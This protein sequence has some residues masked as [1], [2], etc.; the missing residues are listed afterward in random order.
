MLEF[1]DIG[2]RFSNVILQTILVLL[3]R[4]PPKVCLQCRLLVLWI[5][6]R[7]SKYSFSESEIAVM[8]IL[9]EALRV[10]W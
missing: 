1:V 2:P 4:I 10:L 5:V 8:W 6:V 7:L 3:K 9:S